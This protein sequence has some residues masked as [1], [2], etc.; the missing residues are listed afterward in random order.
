[1]T[2]MPDDRNG[3][4]PA[5]ATDAVLTALAGLLVLLSLTAAAFMAVPLLFDETVSGRGKWI[6]AILLAVLLGIAGS[7]A[8]GLRLLRLRAG[9]DAP[10]APRVRKM[11]RLS[12]LSGLVAVPGIL[13]LAY[14]SPDQE[15]PAALFSNSPVSR[16]IAIG[17]IAGWLLAMALA[18]WWHASADEHERQANAVGAIAGAALF[19]AAAPAW[20]VAARAGILPPPDAMILWC[21]VMVVWMIGWFWRRYR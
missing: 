12:A 11:N 3:E 10:I 13:A 6:A 4:R 2:A 17:A 14:G 9:T 7:A 5:S 18:W 20:W 8:W 15:G 19:A 1:M 16:T 21:A